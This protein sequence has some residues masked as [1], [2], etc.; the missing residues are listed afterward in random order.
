M[1]KRWYASWW[2]SAWRL[3]W[4]CRRTCATVTSTWGGERGGGRGGGG[5]GGGTFIAFQK[6]TPPFSA[7]LVESRNDYNIIVQKEHNYIR[8]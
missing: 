4:S 5:G 7:H 6:A 1:K 8:I 3:S 2:K